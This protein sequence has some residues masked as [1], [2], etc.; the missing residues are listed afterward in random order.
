M[1]PETLNFILAFIVGCLIA[2]YF[3]KGVE[4]FV[5]LFLGGN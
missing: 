5:Y 4:W 3:M 1:N 2:T